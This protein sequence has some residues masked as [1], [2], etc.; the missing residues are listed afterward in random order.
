MKRFL[1][2]LSLI[3]IG[4]IS[5][6]QSDESEPNDVIPMAN[7][8]PY[9]D[10]RVGTIGQGDNIDYHKM[11]LTTYSN[12]LIYLEITNTG[13][14]T[15]TLYTKVYNSLQFGSEY[16]GD[17]HQLGYQL[18]PGSTMYDTIWLCGKEP[19]DFFFE[20][21]GDGDFEYKIEWYPVNSYPDDGYNNTPASA[22][23]FTYNVEKQGSIGYEFWG[24]SVMDTLDYY[25]STLP[26]ANYD[27]ITL[28]IRGINNSCTVRWLK[29]ACY[30]NGNPVPFASGYVGDNPAVGS[31]GQVRTGIPLSG[32]AQGD[33]L[34]VKLSSY[35]GFGYG[36]SGAFGYHLKYSKI[37]EFEPDIEDNCCPYNAIELAPGQIATGNVGE[38]DM[39]S[40]T[41]IDQFDTYKIT[42]PYHG[43]VNII[44]RARNDECDYES[45]NLS[46]DLVDPGGTEMD[47]GDLVYMETNWVCNLVVSDTIKIRGF[48]PG[49]YYFRLRTDYG[50]YGKVSYRFKYETL[51]ST[52]NVD[53]EPNFQASNAIPIAAG[54]TRRG[55]MNFV[56]PT[57]NFDFR[58]YYKT[59]LPED[60][61]LRVYLKI[62]FRENTDGGAISFL[63]SGFNRNVSTGPHQY[64]MSDST[65]Y[66]TMDICGAGK[67][68]YLLYLESYHAFEYEFRYEII[69]TIGADKD[70][71]PNNTFAQ[72]TLVGA[73]VTKQGHIRYVNSTDYDD[74]DYYKMV[75]HSP[76]S[77]KIY[78]QAT[79]ASCGNNRSI[80][81]R[82]YGKNQGALQAKV[83]NGVNAG[84]TVTDSF[85]INVPNPIDS[86]YVRIESSSAFRY[87]M[88]TNLRVPSSTFSIIGDTAV[89]VSTQVYKAVRVADEPVVYNWVLP[90]G[91][92]TLTA[93]DSI[94]TVVWT[95]TG[96][97]RIQ[98]YLSNAKGN[99]QVKTRN[100][101]INGFP[102]TQVPVAY[103]FA[104]TLSTNSFP[105]GTT[106]QWFRNDTLIP[107]AVNAS[108]YAAAAGSYTVTFVNDC[109][110]GPESNAIV[111]EADALPQTITFPH[112]PPVTM[113]PTAKVYLNASSNSGLP[114]FYQKISGGGFIQ[115]DTLYIIGNSIIGD[116]IIKAVQPGD[117]VY[118][119]ATDKYDTITVLKGSQV[120]IF[121][122][123]PDQVLDGVQLL[124]TARSDMGLGITY[125]IVG[126][127]TL[128][129]VDNDNDKL[130]K[131]G[132]GIV[133]V[134]ASQNGN[135]N[136]FAATPVERSFCIGVRTLTP[137]TGDANPCLSTYRYN[138]V[139]IPGALYEWTL[140]GGGILTTHNDTAWVQWQVPGTYTLKVKANS[141]CDTT[142][143]NEVEYV[144]S[145]S[146][147]VPAPVSNML[148]VNAAIDQQL[149]LTLSW[150]P[151]GNTVNYDL[152]IWDSEATEPL[153]PYA[154]NIGTVSFVL[155]K[156]SFAYNRTYKW[157]IVSK[158][159]CS[160]TSSPIQTFS[161]IPLADLVISDIQAPLNVNSGQT[162][163]ISWKVTN[164]GP[165][166]TL[167]DESWSDGIFF[168]FDTMPNFS[169]S[170]NW[171]P[172]S[173][174]SLTANGRPL[175]VGTKPNVEALDSGE[176]YTNSINFTI[177]ANYNQPL[178][179][180]GITDYPRRSSA[181][182]QVT[183]LNDTARAPQP[184]NVTLSPTP[185]LRTDSVFVPTSVFSG[186]TIN[187]AYKV[188][189]YGVVTP[190]GENWV[191]SIFISQ[192]PLFDRAQSIPL[193][194]V[195]AN[196]SYYPNAINA[197]AS[198]NSQLPQD[199]TYTKNVEVVIPNFI[200]G[201]WFIYVKANAA[202]QESAN[203]YEGSLN[204]NNVGQAQ[205]QVYL[206]PT[207]KLTVSTLA[208]PVTE[209]STTQPIGINWNIFNEGFTDNF[210]R[211]KG[212]Y[213]Y[214]QIGS[215]PCYSST[216]NS[217]CYGPP[218]YQDSL[219]QGSSYWVDRVYLSKDPGG[220]NIANAVLIKEIPHGKAFSGMDYPDDFTNQCFGY[221]AREVNV[222]FALYPGSNFPTALNFNVPGDLQPGTYYIYV[223]TNPT[224]TVFEYPGTPQIKRSDLP[225]VIG[226]PDLTV[227]S[228]SSPSIAWGS[229]PMSVT[230]EILNTGVGSVFSHS[231]T[232]RLYMSDFPAFDVSAQLVGTQT[233]TESV[234]VGVSVP[235]TF[236]YTAPAAT[237]G[238]KYFYV[239]TNYDSA[240]RETSYTNNL[241]VS[242]L[243]T[244]TAAVAADLIVTSITPADSVF[245]IYGSPFRYRVTNNGSGTTL[246]TWTDSIY[247]SCSPVYTPQ[248]SYAVAARTHTK[249]IGAG[250]SYE[251]TFNLKLPLSYTINACFPVQMYNNVHFFVRTNA[252]NATYEGTAINNNVN[253]SGTWPLINPL[254]DHII[255]NVTANDTTKVGYNYLVSH[256]TKNIGYNPNGIQYYYSYSDAVYFSTDS[257]LDVNDVKAS[258]ILRYSI[259]N[260]HEERV[261]NHNLL[262]PN[263]PT[264]DYYVIARTNYYESIATEKV[265]ANN[266]NL[267]RN[268]DGS[269]KKI[270]V[271]RP[272]LPDLRDS[273]ISAPV[274][275]ALGQPFTVKYRVKNH[276]LGATNPL[277][278][279]TALR[280]SVDLAA[281]PNDG[282]RLLGT[283]THSQILQPG[284]SLEDSIT[285]TI[286]GYTIPANY[287]LLSWTD[288]NTDMIESDETNNVGASL[289]DAFMPP[290]SDL[291]TTKIIAPDT[292]YLGYTIDT[293]KWVVENQS[294]E[295]AKGQTRDGVYLWQTG[296][297]DSTTLSLIGIRNKTINMQPLAV[298]T[299]RMAPMVDNVPEGEYNVLIRTDLLDNIPETDDQNNAY[300]STGKI[301][302]KV[303]P[304]QLGV[305][306]QN[307]LHTV[308]I[309]YKIEVP[310]SLIGSTIMV[311]LKS[312][313]SLTMRN[314]IYLGAG[315]IP[316]NAHHDYKFEIPNYGNQQIVMTDVSDSVYY[317][318]ITAVSP[319]PV[320]QS[321]RVKAEVLPFA[322]L[323]VNASS[324][325]NIGNVT[326][327]ISGSLFS[328]GMRA[329]LTKGTAIIMSTAVYYTNST[330]VYATFNLQGAP[331]GVYDVTLIKADSS[332]AMREN[333]FTIVVANN[334]GL[335]TGSGPNTGAGNPNEPG[336]DPGA[337]SG[338]NSQLSVELVV[339][340]KA[341]LGR[342]V[343]IEVHYT[344]PT[345]FDIPA[346][347]RILYSDEGVK[348]AFTKE[349]VP[350]GSTSLY[351]ELVEAGGPPGII[352][353]GGSGTITIHTVAPTVVP[354]DRIVLF[355]LK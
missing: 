308:K 280:L 18:F 70:V 23:F 73:N 232:D 304:L 147:N 107:G 121:D 89:C 90:D 299:V 199:A 14:T 231:R 109:G 24:N 135:A 8:L 338:M 328:P 321:I 77:L 166:R 285:V 104:R 161:L 210:E 125:S 82:L 254:V 54:E 136:Y 326:V 162:V 65:Y 267:I 289:L 296:S 187:L 309:F 305:E 277:T 112:N 282:D 44:L 177:P 262:T 319:N 102:P 108:Y 310:D 164:I 81:F 195:K 253:G 301:Y 198:V 163:T 6:S 39:N 75:Y 157:K 142:Y 31:F 32:M 10:I 192:N 40:D 55:N 303:K 334:G 214:K 169:W 247:I 115:N 145:T 272:L 239:L 207:P 127:T 67:G 98:L 258:H 61:N 96:N 25:Q 249:R 83:K 295:I 278:W 156:N 351:L 101:I 113:S 191:D 227:S 22:S 133:T 28:S 43:S 146:S 29:Y 202:D 189:N 137:I 346:Q 167:T 151:G 15:K 117:D 95:T 5:W 141:P 212:H 168:S 286:P 234:P 68:E 11:E 352:R 347:S 302:V 105:A 76:D 225:I 294:P 265:V 13:S 196:N 36:A 78:F 134:R 241:S 57:S 50:N 276:G 193:K 293:V 149:P 223:Y 331:L 215:C 185:D 63:G 72:A 58:D 269:A 41:F 228:V 213:L 237:T 355:K 350:T 203:V 186:S 17:F 140:S 311:T 229:Q 154:S 42:V 9:G 152:Y 30:K 16:V 86:F 143:S 3:F 56:S 62:I 201:T 38:Y 184:I 118:L 330:T 197:N 170:P 246:G 48:S 217:V 264:G 349:G 224:K 158:N 160:I 306:E 314:E 129:T 74:Y 27:S 298:D 341:L 206:A 233:F 337:P 116:I 111:F 159:P 297:S 100:V 34:L 242:T 238:A 182:L 175:L 84:Q 130:T 47:G 12:I 263:I 49:D 35:G 106:A 2:L 33:V 327:K 45:Y 132:A 120:I 180:Y 123:I 257:I 20:L 222:E 325:G 181:P 21:E 261:F 59:V 312:N 211:N 71:E 208:V 79:N 103:N 4:L 235:H 342:P 144:I 114:V 244:Y 88:T 287:F 339:P 248:T 139:R 69:E 245:T 260:R 290:L 60:G 155:P 268:E 188:K 194:L 250:E 336:C 165:G 99:S 174:S 353:A 221:A 256:A 274:S 216:P 270:H 318:S 138:T 273:I 236:T 183:V 219:A 179:V 323:N 345:N 19:D 251:D 200:F 332:E 124:M 1:L 85:K 110:P 354:A 348:M 97:R 291:V 64:F 150:I 279:R 52:G 87:N 320:V 284:E 119:P 259:L 315:Y 335:I 171:N 122:S 316:N 178:Y 288:S 271:I 255:T 92:G 313:D 37:S 26:V 344:N 329:T 46:Y 176:F 340:P 333:A 218:R 240:F 51:D 53:P 153:L 131:K 209:A 324:G 91:G 307:T 204:G 220:L 80:T 93:N 126:S 275:V 173:W 230:Y 205:L 128:A 300:T 292:V 266:S 7:E 66:D 281:N 190:S 252:N 148:P 322:I 317:L 172:S 226:R 94:A 343:V 243:T 283:R